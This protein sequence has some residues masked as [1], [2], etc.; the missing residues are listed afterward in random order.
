MK[1]GKLHIKRK[2]K[3]FSNGAISIFLCIL[4]TPIL[5]LTLSMV[6]YA[7]Y[8][9]VI[10]ITKE[11]M[12][13]TGVSVT[14]DYDVYLHDRFGLLA[15][16]QDGDVSDGV[17]ELLLYNISSLGN[18]VDITDGSVGVSGRYALSD[19]EILKKQMVAV[20]ELTGPS[21]VILEDLK[22]EQLLEQLNQL[23]TFANLTTTFQNMTA[24]TTALTEAINALEELKDAISGFK[25]ALSESTRC[26]QEFTTRLNDLIVLINTSEDLVLPENPTQEDIDNLLNTFVGTYLQSIKDVCTSANNFKNSI[27]AV[28]ESLTNINGKIE[29]FEIKVE[30]VKS[31]I[32]SARGGNQNENTE[33]AANPALI[34]IE[35]VVSEMELLI[36]ECLNDIKEGSLNIAK[37]EIE[38]VYQEILDSSGLGPII[39]RYSQIINGQYFDSIPLDENEKEDLMGL[40]EV[41]WAVYAEEGEGGIGEYLEGLFIPDFSSIDI[42]YILS[43]INDAIQRALDSI[44]TEELEKATDLFDKLVDLLKQLFN[45]QLFFDA[46]LNSFVDVGERQDNPYSNFLKYVAG[47]FDAV[48]DIE[49]VFDGD[50]DIEEL[51]DAVEAFDDLFECAA[52]I[53]SSLF[54]MA[55]DTFGGIIEVVSSL[56]GGDIAALYEKLCVAAYL[57]HNLPS[58]VDAA[59]IDDG[60]VT[61][62]GEGL[63]QFSYNDIVRPEGGSANN[64]WSEGVRGL[65]LFLDSMSNGGSGDDS[66]FK[67]A[68]LE[69]VL[70][71]SNSEYF[72]QTM[73]FMQVYSLRFVCGLVGVFGDPFVS[74]A[75]TAA[76]I[77]ALIVYILYMLIEPLLDTILLVNGC[78]VPLVK[79]RCWVTPTGFGKFVAEFANATTSCEDI[80]EAIT[81]KG[82][83]IADKLSDYG[84]GGNAS[85]SM[86]FASTGYETHLLLLLLTRSTDDLVNNFKDIVELEA[87]AYYESKG[88]TFSLE[89]AFTAVVI[90]AEVRFNPFFDVGKYFAGT[91]LDMTGNV[92]QMVTY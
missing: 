64:D 28:E 44:A 79:T 13:L 12:E 41:A 75:A 6:E 9:E 4:M 46:S 11:L 27:T 7:R 5:S 15:T 55:F 45:M 50:T 92:K 30:A 77:G 83:Q 73:V 63:T 10:S 88:K 19:T 70:T 53:M 40:L 18:Q 31:A 60:L 32:E 17:S 16:T 78:E 1:K 48:E 8:Q 47:I 69:Y 80:R 51:K 14:A 3:K 38:S 74:S 81:N 68:E 35:D 21:A 58:R 87:T 61:L 66:M 85:D 37:D 67:G 90:E 22:L 62:N 76:T 84:T 89:K 34:T 25:D 23:Q 20:S 33:E 39:N 52:G 2:I 42:D 36:D 91:P 24:V 59:G 86:G 82:N 71:G 29:N 49:D 65:R 26:A 56:V 72:N 54:E 57:R 43:L